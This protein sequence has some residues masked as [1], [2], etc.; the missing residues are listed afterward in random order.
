MIE[1]A[2]LCAFTGEQIEDR[3]LSQS[4]QRICN[5]KV[6]VNEAVQFGDLSNY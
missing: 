1:D 2:F 4:A 5:V 6:V 3:D